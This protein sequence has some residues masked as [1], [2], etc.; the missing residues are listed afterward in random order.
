M[1]L[2]QIRID[3]MRGTDERQTSFFILG[4][5]ESMIPADEPLRAL[6]TLVDE[7]LAKLD[8]DFA[9][10]YARD[11]RPSIAP[12]QL[13]RAT[14]LMMVES[15]RSELQVV[16]SIRFN[17]LHRWF[18]GLGVTDVVWDAS[19]FS[20]NR[21]RLLRHEIAQR[22]LDEVVALARSRDL[23][24]DDH[25]TAD[26]THLKASA[27]MKTFLPRDDDNDTGGQSCGDRN[28][29]VET[30]TGKLISR[31]HARLGPNRLAGRY[32]IRLSIPVLGD[33]IRLVLGD[34]RRQVGSP[35]YLGK[36]MV[37]N[38]FVLGVSRLLLFVTILFLSMTY[39]GANENDDKL[40]EIF[41]QPEA[42]LV[43]P[44]MDFPVTCVLS[45]RPKGRG[46]FLSKPAADSVVS[47]LKYY[48]SLDSVYVRPISNA[49][50][51]VFGTK[52]DY[53]CI[54]MSDNDIRPLPQHGPTFTSV[55][56]TVVNDGANSQ[57]YFLV[58]D[59]F[60]LAGS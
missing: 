11:G 27:S 24:S 58:N 31:S 51:N 28:Q 40:I 41:G 22:F 47:L 37:F 49:Q 35:V 53:A 54:A 6:R 16:R 42:K 46:G 56:I 25:L 33:P 18:V 14:I 15:L 23:I 8:G 55:T 17:V 38:S 36:R 2:K 52:L 21:E 4:D 10:M 34:T 9:R 50:N 20:K 13:L 32:R 1:K 12:E 29:S 45:S 43:N 57:M 19:T 48:S 5:V 30:R 26:G 39:C 59:L 44:V 3:F 60:Y 7:V